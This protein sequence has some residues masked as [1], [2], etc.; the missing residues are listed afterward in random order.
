MQLLNRK[1]DRGNILQQYTRQG[2]LDNTSKAQ[3]I[4]L[5]LKKTNRIASKSK[6][7]QT[8]EGRKNYSVG[9]ICEDCTSD[10]RLNI[11]MM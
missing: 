9:E 10:K 8:P 4:K 3:A 7:K 11:Q 2:L 6:A 1:K 5:K